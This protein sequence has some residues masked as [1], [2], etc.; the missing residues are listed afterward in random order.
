[1]GP[2]GP[3]PCSQEPATGPYHDPDEFSSSSHVIRLRLF[4]KYISISG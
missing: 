4:S 3:L 1:M 2:E